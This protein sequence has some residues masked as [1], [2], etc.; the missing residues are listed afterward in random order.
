MEHADWSLQLRDAHELYQALLIDA[1]VR[2]GLYQRLQSGVLDEDLNQFDPRFVR[3]V[4]VALESFGYIQRQG[5]FVR[6]VN[7]AGVRRALYLSQHLR[8][9]LDLAAQLNPSVAEN[10]ASDY[11]GL[12]LE[13]LNESAPLLAQWIVEVAGVK[14]E[15]RWLDVGSGSG[16]LGTHLARYTKEVILCDCPDVAGRW[17]RALWPDNVKALALNILDGDVPGK[18]DG[19]LLC[20]FV[21]MVAPRQVRFLFTK[22]FQILEPYGRLCLVGY[23]SPEA[24]LYDLFRVQVALHV[25]DG[26]V[27]SL[28]ELLDLASQAGFDV[29]GALVQRRHGYDLLCLKAGAADLEPSSATSTGHAT[30]MAGSTNNRMAA[31]TGTR[32]SFVRNPEPV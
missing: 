11:D 8:R 24:P 9:W 16:L 26:H 23:F 20:R 25:R 22:I 15:Q 12:G 13:V 21:E 18:F 7:T 1:S 32:T 6:W 29:A 31:M 19:V 3:S 5:P 27:Y 10:P 14:K 28:Q 17:N 2:S 4:L 30:S